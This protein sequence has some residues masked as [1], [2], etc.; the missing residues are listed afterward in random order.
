MYHYYVKQNPTELYYERH[1]LLV[2]RARGASLARKAL[3]QEAQSNWTSKAVKG[4][5]SLVVAALL[6][7]ALTLVGTSS[8]AH[9]A[10]TFTVNSTSDFRDENLDDSVNL[11]DIAVERPGAQCT[12]RAAIEEANHT[13][14]TD[15]IHFNIREDVDPGVKTLQPFT[16]LPRIMEGVTIDGYT[17]PSSCANTLSK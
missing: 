1:Q 11:C 16:E 13:P 15:A 14:G 17:Q 5:L 9:A 2:G 3:K 4:A 8:P 6:V 7:A 10:T 12:L